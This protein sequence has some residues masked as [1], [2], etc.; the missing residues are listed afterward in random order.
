MTLTSFD[1]SLSFSSGF[2]GSTN[3]TLLMVVLTPSCGWWWSTIA[4]TWSTSNKLIN[5]STQANPITVSCSLMDEKKTWKTCSTMMRSTCSLDGFWWQTKSGKKREW[6]RWWCTDMNSLFSR[7]KLF[8]GA[9]DAKL[10]RADGSTFKRTSPVAK[11]FKVFFSSSLAT[12]Y[13]ISSSSETNRPEMGKK[14]LPSDWTSFSKWKMSSSRVVSLC[15]GGSGEWD[16]CVL[17][18]ENVKSFIVEACDARVWKPQ[19][20]CVTEVGKLR[21]A[22]MP[23][24]E[25]FQNVAAIGWREQKARPSVKAAQRNLQNVVAQGAGGAH[26]EHFMHEGNSFRSGE[27][28]FRIRT[29]PA[30]RRIC[31]MSDNFIPEKEAHDSG[32]L[33]RTKRFC[34]FKLRYQRPVIIIYWG[35]TARSR[36][37]WSEKKALRKLL[38]NFFLPPL[39]MTTFALLVPSNVKQRKVF[40][41]ASN[42]MLAGNDSKSFRIRGRSESI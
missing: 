35:V 25:K 42:S 38:W 19:W 30:Q 33:R 14:K 37:N 9:K 34:V 15:E 27:I 29:A 10:K 20:M 1:S 22:R 32:K 3:L 21:F 7:M 8:S 4:C 12:W 23:Q 26:S 2:V 40:V 39:T 13:E 18:V 6:C 17:I 11:H 36:L 41:A 5:I 24:P 16:S 31:D 28:E